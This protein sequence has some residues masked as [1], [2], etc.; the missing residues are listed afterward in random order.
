MMYELDVL[1][2]IFRYRKTTK[3]AVG[4]RRI[5]RENI[6]DCGLDKTVLWHS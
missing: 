3:F 2:D 1:K 4:H 6:F 5:L